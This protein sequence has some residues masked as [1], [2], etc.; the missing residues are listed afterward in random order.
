M[1]S[2]VF[3]DRISVVFVNFDI[4]ANARVRVMGIPIVPPVPY[5]LAQ[6]RPKG[7]LRATKEDRAVRRVT[8]NRLLIVLESSGRAP[9]RDAHT[10][11][12]NC[13][14]FT[15][16]RWR[17]RVVIATLLFRFQVEN[18]CQL[19]RQL[20]NQIVRRR[21]KVVFRID[22]NSARFLTAIRF[23]RRQGSR[24]TLT[25]RLH[26]QFVCVQL[27]REVRRLFLGYDLFAIRMEHGDRVIKE[28]DVVNF[29]VRSSSVVLR[30]HHRAVNRAIVVRARG[31]TMIAPR[32]RYRFVVSVLC[33]HLF[34]REE[35]SRFVGYNFRRFQSFKTNPWSGSILR[36]RKSKEYNGG[37]DP[38]IYG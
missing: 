8:V 28:R 11:Y 23:R 3:N 26:S 37:F 15:F 10:T 4:S 2:T 17:L 36:H 35:E 31:G 24:R 5:R 34:V 29:F 14:V 13:M 22:L 38:I 9:Q 25:I 20:I 33:F 18:R 16:F 30:L 27:L 21:S 6:F 19:R 32:Q 12:L 7:V 1:F